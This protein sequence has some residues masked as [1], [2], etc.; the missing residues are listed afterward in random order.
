[1]SSIILSVIQTV[2]YPNYLLSKLLV[3]QTISYPNC[4]SSKL[5]V[6]Q[7]ICYPNCLSSQRRLGS[8]SSILR[9]ASSYR[10]VGQ[11]ERSET[12]QPLS[13]LQ[14]QERPAALSFINDTVF[15]QSYC[16]PSMILF[17]IHYTVCYPNRLSSKL[18][19]IQT[20]ATQTV[21]HPNCLLPK[22]FVIQTICYPNRLSSQRRLGSI[23]STLRFASSYRFVGQI[24]RSETQQPLSQLQLLERPAVLSFI[25]DTVFHQ[26][27]CLPS[28]ILYVIH[29]TVCYPNRLSSK[30]FVLQIICHPNCLLSKLFVIQTICYPN[31]LSSKPFVIP[32]K[33]GIHF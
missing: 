14:L 21:C 33:A 16:L 26:S 22:L 19:V 5:L 32:A 6:I 29:Y 15:H 20:V 12:Q 8:I 4:L 30:P 10:F 23:S 24:E 3:I 17:V 1:V 2:C 25:N 28:M 18:F 9:L 7:T 31:C 27:Y 11:I 13:Q